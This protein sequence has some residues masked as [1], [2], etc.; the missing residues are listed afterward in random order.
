MFG[1][2]VILFVDMLKFAIDLRKINEIIKFW[3]FISLIQITAR[4]NFVVDGVQ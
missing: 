4:W 3:M 2:F 1:I